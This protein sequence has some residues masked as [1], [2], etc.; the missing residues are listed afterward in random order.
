M[1]HRH[2]PSRFLAACALAGT[3]ASIGFISVATVWLLWLFPATFRLC[4]T[5]RQCYCVALVFY[6]VAG[7]GFLLGIHTL[8]ESM[9]TPLLAWIFSAATLATPYTVI[10]RLPRCGVLIALTLTM[11]PPVGL[12]A[13]PTPLIGAGVT[14]PG[15]GMTGFILTLLIYQIIYSAQCTK[16]ALAT[17]LIGLIGASTWSAAA[18]ITPTARAWA[19]INTEYHSALTLTR[20]FSSD[21]AIQNEVHDVLRIQTPPSYNDTTLVFPEAAGGRLTQAAM[22]RLQSFASATGR[23]FLIGGEEYAGRGQLNNVLVHVSL[24]HTD[25]VYRQRLPAPWF[26]FRGD[27][28]GFFTADLSRPATFMLGQQRVGVM[29]CY[30]IALPFF[31]LQTHWGNPEVVLVAMNLWWAHETNLPDLARLHIKAWSRLYGVPY[32]LAMNT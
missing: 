18:S 14:F 31:V 13:L 17:L 9:V 7:R 6:L 29:I 25:V 11:I 27:R 26:M 19:G 8:S 21:F 2:S 3:A 5:A 22:S 24:E 15:T 16:P 12:I 4:Q 20:D 23:S 28:P 1:D 10:P 30:E 32:V